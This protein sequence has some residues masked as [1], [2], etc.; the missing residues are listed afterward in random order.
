MA[1]ERVSNHLNLKSTLVF[2]DY[3]QKEFATFEYQLK[4]FIQWL[5]LKSPSQVIQF[6]KPY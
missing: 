4:I 1:I 6:L 5:E 3:S 2:L